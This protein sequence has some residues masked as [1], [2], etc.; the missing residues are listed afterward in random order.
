MKGVAKKS[1]PESLRGVIA[2]FLSRSGLD[3]QL[4]AGRLGRIWA[5]VAGPALAKRTR[6]VGGLRGGALRIEVD[7]ASLLS[8]L[9]GFESKRLEG[10]MRE[11]FKRTYIQKLSFQLGSWEKKEAG[12]GDT[13]DTENGQSGGKQQ[14]KQPQRKAHGVG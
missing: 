7:S 4:E 2:E 11:K 8:E 3:R 12:H 14:K 9:K 5:E 6:V 1:G 10:L 13:E